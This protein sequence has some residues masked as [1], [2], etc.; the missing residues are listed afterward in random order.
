MQGPDTF[1]LLNV[2]GRCAR[3]ADWNPQDAPKLWAYHLH[4]FD[5][6]NADGALSRGNWH[7]VLL[8]RWVRENPPAAGVGWE[9]YPVSRRIVN[10]M[11]WSL[12]TDSLSAACKESLAVQVR[13]LN[14][15]LEY[16]LMGN[17]LFAN[18]K[19]LVFAGLYFAGP[20]A[21]AWY[22]RGRQIIE[23]QLAEQVLPDGAHFE[24]SPMYHGAFLEDLLDLLNVHAAFAA[25]SP[26]GWMD[27][28]PRMR[29]WLRAMTHPDGEIAFFNDATFGASPRPQQL[30]EYA[31]RLGLGTATEQLPPFLLLASSGYA[32]LAHDRAIVLCDCAQ[33]GPGYLPGHAHAD[34]LSFEMSLSGQRVFVNSGVDR[35]GTDAER[36]RQR[37]TAA[38]NTVVVD[39]ADSSEVWAGFRVARRARTTIELANAPALQIRASHDGYRRLAGRVVHRREWRLGTQCLII[40]DHLVGRCRSIEAFFHLHPGV[41]VTGQSS[42]SLTLRVPGAPEVQLSFDGAAAIRSLPDQWFPAFGLAVPSRCIAVRLAAS[43]LTSSIRWDS[44]R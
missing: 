31:A 40:K 15:R 43:T 6:L 11:K 14:R 29:Q 36:Q 7:R 12:L 23:R 25:P 10:W 41:Q 8:E 30:E 32:R 2:P 1:L 39:G 16:H 35:Y 18:A 5:D 28:I 9:P 42:D 20:E 17:H 19:A 37:G 34:S 26:R 3:A 22:A 33:I 21:D 13:W 38:H 44:V 27:R 24:L 4:Y